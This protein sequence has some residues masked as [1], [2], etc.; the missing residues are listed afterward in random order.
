MGPDLRTT[1]HLIDLCRIPVNFFN[2]FP[3]RGS[4]VQAVQL[5][6]VEE[7][8]GFPLFAFEN[9]CVCSVSLFFQL[10]CN[11]KCSGVTGLCQLTYH[12]LWIKLPNLVKRL[13][14][15]A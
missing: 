13:A 5:A 11:H 12:Q 8:M 1:H 3:D 10:I 7:R 6:V 4:M 15:F 9:P 2:G 14:L